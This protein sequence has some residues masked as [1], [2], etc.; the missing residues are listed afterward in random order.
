MYTWGFNL[1]LFTSPVIY[2]I[3][4][5]SSYLKVTN[6][7]SPD[8]KGFHWFA[9]SCMRERERERERERS[10]TKQQFSMYSF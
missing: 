10:P 1:I 8:T 9:N 4:I 7:D 6:V 5:I 3:Y 2:F